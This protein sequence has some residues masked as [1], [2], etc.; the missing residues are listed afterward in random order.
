MKLHLP[1]EEKNVYSPDAM[2]TEN[3][4]PNTSIPYMKCLES[5]TENCNKILRIFT[6]RTHAIG[7]NTM[8]S[9]GFTQEFSANNKMRRGIILL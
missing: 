9:Y 8:I 3:K 6:I 5:F 4:V 1:E 7:M 2:R